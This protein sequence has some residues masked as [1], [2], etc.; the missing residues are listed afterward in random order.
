MAIILLISCEKATYVPMD[1]PTETDLSPMVQEELERRYEVYI[2]K[3]D[4]KCKEKAL[5]HAISHVDSII[6]EELN[7]NHLPN[8]NVPERPQRPKLPEGIILNDTS[9]VDPI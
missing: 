9:A 5:R 2:S 3:V 7:L 1:V 8:T 6:I 4:Q